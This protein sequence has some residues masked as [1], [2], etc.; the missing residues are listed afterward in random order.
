MET[1]NQ[2]SESD[3]EVVPQKSIKKFVRDIKEYDNQHSLGTAIGKS[4]ADA[5]INATSD[6]NNPNTGS[7]ELP[8]DAQ[9]NLTLENI[10]DRHSEILKKLGIDIE[11]LNKAVEALN[12]NLVDKNLYLQHLKTLPKENLPQETKGLLKMIAEKLDRQV[13]REYSLDS[14]DNRLLELFSGLKDIV[15]EYERLGMNQEVSGLKEYQDYMHSGY[16]REYILARNHGIF[17]PIGTGFTL[18]TLQRDIS[19]DNYIRYWQS[20][21]FD[22]LEEIK[23]NSRAEAFYKKVLAYGKN[24]LDFAEIDLG[25]MR[26]KFLES[27]PECVEYAPDM[28]K[29]IQDTRKKIESIEQ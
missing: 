16:L 17:E 18:S 20:N 27:H 14:A 24:C 8:E 3:R 1:I 9:Q 21:F 13:R 2:S 22:Q 10:Q 25:T 15:A 5:V 23:R 29:A 4:L 26:D 11:S 19:Y 28:K 12:I 7:Q 6:P